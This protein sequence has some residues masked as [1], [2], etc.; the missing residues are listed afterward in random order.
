MREPPRAGKGRS[1]RD[2][3]RLSALNALYDEIYA[4]YRSRDTDLVRRRVIPEALESRVL[5]LG[6]A[7]GRDT[8]R[9][10]GLPYC[11]PS[12]NDPRLS[13]GGEVLDAFL[14]RFGYT[15]RPGGPRQYAYHT[16]L[17]HYFPGRKGRGG[18]DLTPSAEEVARSRRW[19]E[20][21]IR[22]VQPLL[23]VALGKHPAAVFLRRYGG[24]EIK[25]LRDVAARPLSC[26]VGELRLHLIA[27]HHPS[28]AFQ[29]R[30]SSLVYE[31]AAAH[32]ARIL[33]WQSS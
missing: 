10:S 17:V 18:G 3:E 29:H 21:E 25:R 5:L 27:V 1:Y 32:A 4:F 2:S 8:Q 33:S 22:L 23:I 24:I 19:L 31:H 28:G 12:A 26:C 30:Q 14:A 11:F 9:L 6:Q 15:I 20:I 7:S 13:R 16:D